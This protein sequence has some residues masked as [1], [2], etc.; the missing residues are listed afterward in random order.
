MHSVGPYVKARGDSTVHCVQYRAYSLH[1]TVHN[2]YCTVCSTFNIDT[3]QDKMYTAQSMV[4][5]VQT[6]N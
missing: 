3:V 5:T 2:V 4:Y 1:C 6:T